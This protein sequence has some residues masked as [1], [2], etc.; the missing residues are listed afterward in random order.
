MKVLILAAGYGTRLYPLVKDTPKA[1]LDINGKSLVNYVLDK[2]K[3]FDGLSEV[4]LVT[5]NK[6]YSIFVE[7]AKAQKNFSCPIKIVN[8]GTNTPDDR[9]GSIGDI[10][11]VIKK[12]AINE[13][14][15]VIG[16]DNLFDYSL[17]EYILFSKKFK[18]SVTI[19]LY[20]IKNLEEAKNFG[21]VAIDATKKITSFEEKPA[22]PKSTLISMCCY[23]LPKATLGLVEVYLTETK[24][25]DKAGDYLRWLSEKNNVYGFNFFGKWYD[26]G[27]IESYKEAQ[28]KFKN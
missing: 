11:F 18:D 26:I 28:A 2:I 3:S 8:D 13:D 19:G 21:V 27:S 22:N 16:S 20:D 6:F 17:D 1:L 15:L 14:V 23:Y 4:L 7:W 9:L 10:Q 24:K 5:N 12:E 25:A